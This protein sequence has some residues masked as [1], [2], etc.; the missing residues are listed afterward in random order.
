MKKCLLL[1]SC[2]AAVLILSKVSFAQA[3]FIDPTACPCP[4]G[5]PCAV[6]QSVALPLAYPG[7]SVNPR[8]VR[9]IVRLEGR[10]ALRQARTEARHAMPV[11]Q[12]YPVGVAAADAELQEGSGAWFSPAPIAQ[13]GRRNHSV[14]RSGG[15]GSSVNFNFLSAVRTQSQRYAPPPAQ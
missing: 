11:L 2:F 14:Q 9:R 10:M 7:L 1:V 3:L 5:V 15:V 13:T 4:A 8:D 6:G 12:P